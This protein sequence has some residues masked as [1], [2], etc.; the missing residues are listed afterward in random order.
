MRAVA[1]WLEEGVCPT[2]VIGV[3]DVVALGAYDALLEAGL[4]IPEDVA[5]AGFDNIQLAG[6]RLI[7]LTTVAQHIEELAVRAVRML[8]RLISGQS[9]DRTP[10]HEVTKPELL[11][12]RSTIGS[13]HV[14]L[15][16]V[17]A[18]PRFNNGSNR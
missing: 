9:D 4:R 13:D 8:V 1:R 11:V 6:S 2:A 15:A 3:D 18:P 10:L 14:E 7:G 12:R 16:N 5:V 17:F